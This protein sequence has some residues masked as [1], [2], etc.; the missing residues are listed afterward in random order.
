MSPVTVAAKRW[1][2]TTS[3]ST[4]RTRSVYGSGDWITACQV[5]PSWRPSASNWRSHGH[6][7]RYSSV[8]EIVSQNRSGGTS[9][10]HVLAKWNGDGTEASFQYRRC[11]AQETGA[12]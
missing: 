12:R 10:L 4:N 11:Y 1:Q 9:R 7:V 5:A 2:G 6:Q 3:S 8:R